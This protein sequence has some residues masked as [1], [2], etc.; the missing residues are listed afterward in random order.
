MTI[1][2]KYRRAMNK[3]FYFSPINTKK[4]AGVMPVAA[5][6]TGIDD[7]FHSTTLPIDNFVPDYFFGS[8]AKNL[9]LEAIFLIIFS[10][11]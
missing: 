5:L 2:L 8:P 3:R 10:Y 4:A 6:S 9:V 7:L 1:I 11:S